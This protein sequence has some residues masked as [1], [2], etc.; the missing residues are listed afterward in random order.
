M[1]VKYLAVVPLIA[2]QL[3]KN[4]D[5]LAPSYPQQKYGYGCI[6][7]DHFCSTATAGTPPGLQRQQMLSQLL[8][9][10]LQHW[11]TLA[12][13]R[14]K[15]SSASHIRPQMMSV[16]GILQSCGTPVSAQSPACCGCEGVRL[17]SDY[18]RRM[19]ANVRAY[20]RAEPCNLHGTCQ[21]NNTCFCSNSFDTCKARDT[22]SGCETNT[23]SDFNK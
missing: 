12:W 20:C 13:H 2:A 9:E 16:W 3:V 11:Q 15:R 22:T 14:P 1:Q 4:G 10:S 21:T 19:E 18:V 17:I 23:G 6:L 7:Y 8:P 5:F